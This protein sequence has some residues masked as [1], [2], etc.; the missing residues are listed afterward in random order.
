MSNKLTELLLVT[1]P[2]VVA[3]PTLAAHATALQ[4][5]A[6]VSVAQL[7]QLAQQP[8]VGSTERRRHPSL[9]RF[10]L[11][12]RR[13][14]DAGFLA[15]DSLLLAAADEPR[16][17]AW[18]EPL[19]LLAAEEPSDLKVSYIDSQLLRGMKRKS[20]TQDQS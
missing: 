8:A 6:V 16:G 3:K 14:I 2:R 7:A 4:V 19:F 15:A 20:E 10:P 12:A 1:L 17:R 18:D 9:Q 13:L 11:Q 5:A